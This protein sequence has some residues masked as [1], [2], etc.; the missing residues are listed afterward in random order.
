MT[1]HSMTKDELIGF[2]TTG[3]VD[4]ERIR[5]EGLKTLDQLH[6]QIVERDMT[7]AVYL[8]GSVFFVRKSVKTI[9]TAEG[10]ILIEV[11]RR[12]VNPENQ[13]RKLIIADKQ[14][15]IS[16]SRRVDEA[17]TM[18]A[19]REVAEELGIHVSLS[20]FN[21]KDWANSDEVYSHFSG[22]VRSPGASS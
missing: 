16:G 18:T 7:P 14:Y 4:V 19:Q 21:V 15:S 17:P 6:R 22:L 3:K 2:L 13:R 5:R 8:D 12:Y 10:C 20:D 1:Y 9:V 11:M